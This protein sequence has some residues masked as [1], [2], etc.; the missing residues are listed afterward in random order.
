MPVDEVDITTSASFAEGAMCM[1]Q[2]IFRMLRQSA[3]SPVASALFVKLSPAAIRFSK[4]DELAATA[5]HELVRLKKSRR[6]SCM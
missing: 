2:S 3:G 1:W 6:S 5:R 4:S